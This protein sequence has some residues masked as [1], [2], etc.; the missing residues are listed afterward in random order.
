MM[1]HNQEIADN[2]AFFGKTS[3]QIKK[4]ELMSKIEKFMDKCEGSIEK[5]E[6]DGSF[7]TQQGKIRYG[8]LQ[9]MLD[10]YT[11]LY[12]TD[13][14]NEGELEK[15]KWLFNDGKL[16]SREEIEYNEKLQAA[17]QYKDREYPADRY[18]TSAAQ[19]DVETLMFLLTMV[20]FP[21]VAGAIGFRS[22][23]IAS[24]KMVFTL[25]L[26]IP[27]FL[28]CYVLFQGI[29]VAVKAWIEK[30]LWDTA[31]KEG[32]RPELNTGLVA[33]AVLYGAVVLNIFKKRRK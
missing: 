10:C 4:A 18:D 13:M 8:I 9:N 27:S 15:I 2:A 24:T 11:S 7:K 22:D 32:V 16:R 14:Q 29:G 33:D 23:E 17:K 19:N 3:F 20:V 26:C 6:E 12:N 1:V 25:I 31:R 5:G 28:I 30:M 21:A